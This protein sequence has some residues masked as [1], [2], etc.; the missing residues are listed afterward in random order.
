MDRDEA[1][2]LLLHA[3]NGSF[4]VRESKMRHGEFALVLKHEN[5]VRHLKIDVLNVMFH[6]YTLLM[7]FRRSMG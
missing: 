3:P 1:G 4:C 2:A 6:E 5:V 7:G